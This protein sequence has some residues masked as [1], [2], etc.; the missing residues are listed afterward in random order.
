MLLPDTLVAR[1]TYAII[2]NIGHK[3][4]EKKGRVLSKDIIPENDPF[5]RRND[6][7]PSLLD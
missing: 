2:S 6:L 5:S 3:G 4:E 7:T 1:A